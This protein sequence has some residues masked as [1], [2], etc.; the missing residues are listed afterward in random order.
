MSEKVIKKSDLAYQRDKDKEKVKG[1]FRFYEVPGG[2]MSFVY[3]KYKE[4]PV[5]NYTMIDGQVYTVP[6]S[7][8][9]HLNNS[10]KYPIHAYSQDDLGNPIPIIGKKVA[11]YGFQSLEFV[12]LEDTSI[13]ANSSFGLSM[14]R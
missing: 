5:E 14:G 4:D 2:S 1:I 7:V 10:G 13:P 9:R 3:K 12:D 8:A 11:R 6:L